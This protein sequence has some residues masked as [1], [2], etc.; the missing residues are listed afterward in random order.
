MNWYFSL[1]G[2]HV[3]VRVFFNGAKCGDLCFRVDEWTKIV[4][5]VNGIRS[6]FQP[7]MKGKPLI[8]VIPE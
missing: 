5:C 3:H 4:A 8:T 7:E 1:R 6:L 2:G